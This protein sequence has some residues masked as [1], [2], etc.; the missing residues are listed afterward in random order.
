MEVIRV[1]SEE[2]MKWSCDEVMSEEVMQE[3]KENGG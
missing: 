3:L 2:V 1:M